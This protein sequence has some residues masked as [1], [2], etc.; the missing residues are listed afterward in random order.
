MIKKTAVICHGP[1]LIESNMGRRIDSFMHVVRFLHKGGWQTAKD[2]GVRTS[3][4][5]A[6]V[7]RARTRMR[8]QKPDCGYFFWS[9]TGGILDKRQYGLIEKFGGADMTWLVTAWQKFLPR[10]KHP[11]FSHG[12]AGILIAAAVIKNPIVVFG[13]DLLKQ[14][15]DCNGNYI[16]SWLYEGREQKE[17]GHPLAAERGLI[18]KFSKKYGVEITFV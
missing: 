4:F 1:S 8:N 3:Y 2:Y 10:S 11:F 5:C 9:K 13:A 17:M 18:D 7:G 6:T 12:T 16:G 14:G 15:K